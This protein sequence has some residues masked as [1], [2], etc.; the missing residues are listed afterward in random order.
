[1]ARKLENWIKSYVKHRNNSESPDAFHFWTAVATVAGALRRRVWRDELAFHWTPNFYIILVGPPG[2]VSKS[3][4]I[5]GGFSLL[6]RIPEIKF[7]PQSATWQALFEALT[8]SEEV[9]E[10]NNEPHIMSCLTCSVSELGTFLRTDDK[11]FVA[12]LI[13][14][15]DGQLTTFA[16]RTR[17]DGELKARNPWLN[18][19]AC[20]TPS[21][22][23]ENC[24]T[25]MIGG[26]LFSRIMFVYGDK[27]KRLVAY[28]SRD[29][30]PEGFKQEEEDLVHD[31]IQ[32]STLK[33][34]YDLEETAFAWG[35]N[36]Y[37]E[38][39]EARPE[40][41]NGERFGGYVARKQAH[42]HKLA[43][44]LAASKRDALI[45]TSDDLSE[46]DFYLSLVEKDMA[47]VFESVGQSQ[48]GR[49]AGELL[50]IIR[51]KSPVE[52]KSLWRSASSVMSLREFKE[53][54]S[55]LLEAQHCRME[56]VGSEHVVKYL[57]K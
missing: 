9:V 1:V 26:G 12:Q 33:G 21:W 28:P 20:T 18:I 15:W 44:V 34:H 43:M 3:T 38:L 42:L 48:S 31:L 54:F 22:I 10:I 40:H 6:E 55:G 50:S 51:T 4:S 25:S 52:Y 32:I 14:M 46:A 7:G 8:Q 23:V 49:Q 11:E 39:Y 29:V 5:R 56:Q 41:L 24:P 30:E 16:R 27:K 47:R 53:A 37:R 17:M 13:D 36:W 19:V 45:I 35:E 57:G 2:V